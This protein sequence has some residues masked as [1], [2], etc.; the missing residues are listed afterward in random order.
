MLIRREL[1]VDHEAVDEV[2]RRA[3]AAEGETNEPAEV[4]LVQGLRT[5]PAWVPSL[6]LVAVDG[7]TIVGHV[8]AT[9]GRLGASVAVGL[10]PIGVLP[11]FQERG[12][13][14]ALMHAVLAAADALEYPMVVLVGDV[15]YYRRFGFVKAASL[16]VSP[17]DPTWD[18]HFQVRTLASYRDDVRG[19]FEYA[20]PFQDL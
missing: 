4:R 18:K 11:E 1:A 13:G 12:V 15:N 9:E 20:A 6:S 7:D 17:P 10:G 16:G 8:V 2:H 5:D 3:F 19:E 14:S